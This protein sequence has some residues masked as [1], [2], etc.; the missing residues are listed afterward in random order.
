[1]KNHIT[2]G[3]V[4]D[5]LGFTTEQ[6]ANLKMRAELMRVIEKELD[7]RHLTQTQAAQILD[8][9]QPRISD[10]RC[11]KIHLFTVD[12]LLNMLSKLDRTVSFTIMDNIAA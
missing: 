11:G 2:K 1:M 3:S 8:V 6:A 9:T 7:R 12:V 10:L 5:D 4:Y